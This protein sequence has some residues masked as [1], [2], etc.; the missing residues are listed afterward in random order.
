MYR[1]QFGPLLVHS[2]SKRSTQTDLQLSNIHWTINEFHV[3]HEGITSS[4]IAYF[5]FLLHLLVKLLHPSANGC[6]IYIN[7]KCVHYVPMEI[8]YPAVSH[9]LAYSPL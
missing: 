7:K 6:I 1:Y 4:A 3:L 8:L 2:C 9:M 5:I